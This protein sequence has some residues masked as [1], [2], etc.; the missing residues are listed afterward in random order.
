MITGEI[1]RGGVAIMNFDPVGGISIAV[2][3]GGITGNKLID[4][5]WQGEAVDGNLDRLGGGAF[6]GGYSEPF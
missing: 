2:V 1:K 6:G 3:E 4:D 5:W